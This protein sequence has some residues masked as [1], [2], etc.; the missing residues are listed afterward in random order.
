MAVQHINDDEYDKLVKEGKPLVVDFWAPWC[1]PCRMIG[2]IFEEISSALG[3]KVTFAK[4]NVDENQ[5]AAS[6]NGVTSIPSIIFFKD[7]KRIDT[8]IGAVPKPMLE[9]KIKAVFA[10]Q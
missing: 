6:Q 7:G 1:G 8:L 4:I 9:Q 5:K 10:I 3:D 2:P